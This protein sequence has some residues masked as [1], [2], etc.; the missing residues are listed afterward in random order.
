MNEMADVISEWYQ[1]KARD[2]NGTSNP[3]CILEITDF[4][5]YVVKGSIGKFR[6]LQ[7]RNL[8]SIILE[9]DL[10]VA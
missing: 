10:L 7:G 9:V 4:N 1:G 8:T 5:E 6:G 2:S 3:P